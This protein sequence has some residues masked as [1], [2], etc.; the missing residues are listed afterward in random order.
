[1]TRRADPPVEDGW[2]AHRRAE[3]E[4]SLMATPAQRLRWLEQAIVFAHR[5]GA[6]PR[7]DGVTAPAS[8]ALESE[9]EGRS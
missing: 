8:D 1:V 3:L 6:L 2:E 5:A 9:R 7:K 4:S